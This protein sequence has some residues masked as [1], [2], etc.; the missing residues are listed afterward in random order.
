MNARA[1]YSQL[2]AQFVTGDMTAAEFEYEFLEMFKNEK[3]SLSDDLY[4]VLNA[5]FIDVDR[6]CGDPSLRDEED[7]D[8][9]AL[10]A[11]AK[12]ALGKLT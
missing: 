9:E 6:Y 2:L 11:S 12:A 1:R 3:E 8:D 4:G 10:A 5:M 7:L